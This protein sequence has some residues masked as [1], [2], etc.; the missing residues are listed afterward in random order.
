VKLVQYFVPGQGR[1]LGVVRGD[2]V[3]D[4]TAPEEGVHS[5][6]DLVEQGKTASGVL[7]RAEWLTRQVHRKAMDWPAL[8]RP[9]SRRAPHLLMPLDPPEVWGAGGAYRQSAEF[10]DEE[11]GAIPGKGIP[12]FAPGQPRPA[13][14]F[15][16]TASRCVGPNAPVMIRSDSLLT[17]ADPEVAVVVGVGGA[18]VGFTACTGVSAR[19]IARENPLYL[20]QAEIYRGCCALGPCLVTPDEVGDPYALRVRYTIIRDGRAVFSEAANTSQFHRRLEELVAWLLKD[21]A[22]PAG[23]VLSTGTGILVPDEFALREGDR[24]DLEVQAIGRL[25]NPVKHLKA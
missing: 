23:T 1:R 12:H 8:Q 4:I 16:A 22:V 5:A 14:F 24:V 13:L 15:K 10:R 3:L 17:A 18:I 19:D 6:L 9:P 25:S 2:R 7:K 11:P 20:P 21:N